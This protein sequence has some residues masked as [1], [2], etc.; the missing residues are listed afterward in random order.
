MFWV[1]VTL[2]SALLLVELIIILHLRRQC[3]MDV[4]L[5]ERLGG[6]P[7][8]I[9]C[10]TLDRKRGYYIRLTVFWNNIISEQISLALTIF[11]LSNWFPKV[12]LCTMS[13]GEVHIML[14]RVIFVLHKS[15]LFNF[16]VSCFFI[17]FLPGKTSV[18]LALC[19]SLKIPFLSW[20]YVQNETHKAFPSKKMEGFPSQHGNFISSYSPTLLDYR[21][22]QCPPK[23]YL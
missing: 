16:A 19:K 22:I 18:N 9:S 11:D 10:V 4:I 6:L 3:L 1:G 13:S 8:C 12:T 2:H 5:S 7:A 14:N 15:V 21:Y 17:D 23:M 20:E